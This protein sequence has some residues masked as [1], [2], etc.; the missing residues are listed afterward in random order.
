VKNGL[1]KEVRRI[2]K[3]GCTNGGDEKRTG[4]I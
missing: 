4:E 3:L 1:E 2:K